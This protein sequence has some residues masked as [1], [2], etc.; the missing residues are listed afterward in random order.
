MG[1]CEKMRDARKAKGYTQE[2]LARKC[3]VSA[4]SVFKWETGRQLPTKNNAL[5]LAR[6]LGVKYA[7]LMADDGRS[8]T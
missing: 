4:I 5:Q 3:N 7:D 8:S 1:F 2:E 6:A